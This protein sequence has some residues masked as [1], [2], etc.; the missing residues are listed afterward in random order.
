M[1][2]PKSRF[3]GKKAHFKI[4]SNYRHEAV[5]EIKGKNG[6]SVTGF[7]NRI[8]P[9][10]FNKD[11]AIAGRILCIHMAFSPITTS[12]GGGVPSAVSGAGVA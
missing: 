3:S 1:Q 2:T 5:T 7:L 8:M 9:V 6:G 4:V 12:S 11:A 10:Q